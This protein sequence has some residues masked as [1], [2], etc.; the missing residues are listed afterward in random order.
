M[1]PCFDAVV[2]ALP[3]EAVFDAFVKV[4]PDEPWVNTVVDALEAR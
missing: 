3:D 4:L 1:R 2:E